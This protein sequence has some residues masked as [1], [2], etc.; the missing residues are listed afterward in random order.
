M[1]HTSQRPKRTHQARIP[2]F[3]EEHQSESAMK[4]EHVIMSDITKKSIRKTMNRS[5]HGVVLCSFH[6]VINQRALRS[7]IVLRDPV[8]AT[9]CHTLCIKYDLDAMLSQF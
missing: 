7:T 5:K 2:G 1:S 6:S 8:V 4:T 3:N 9:A